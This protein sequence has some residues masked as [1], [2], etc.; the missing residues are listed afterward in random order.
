MLSLLGRP[1]KRIEEG[2][3]NEG[4]TK[5][6]SH[7]HGA[8]WVARSALAANIRGCSFRPNQ[9]PCPSCHSSKSLAALATKQDFLMHRKSTNFL[10]L[11]LLFSA[12]NDPSKVVEESLIYHSLGV[13]CLLYMKAFAFTAA[14]E[15][16]NL[17]IAVASL[18]PSLHPI[19]KRRQREREQSKGGVGGGHHGKRRVRW[20]NSLLFLGSRFVVEVFQ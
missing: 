8:C 12:Q 16:G 14:E 20:T 17:C 15:K 18:P 9:P 19:A 3:K 10:R 1:Q 7:S 2:S 11:L 4:A 13:I 5:P 6:S